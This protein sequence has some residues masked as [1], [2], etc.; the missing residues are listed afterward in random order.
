MDAAL[1]LVFMAILGVALLLYVILD[2]YD[3]GIGL[4]L[5]LATNTE[6]DTMIASIGPFWDANETWLVL[7]VGV[8]L[9]AFPVAYGLVLTALYVSVT[10]MLIGLILRG[11]AFDFRVKAAVKHK[12]MWNRA[13]AAGSLL[14]ATAQ[15]WMLGSYITGLV[16]SPVNT[17]FAALIALTLPSLYVVLGTGWLMMK[18][19]GPLFDKAVRWGL[20]A[21]P[22]M[23]IALLAVSVATPIVSEAIA[24]RWFT[25]PNFIG[26]APIPITTAIAFFSVLWV[27]K[28]FAAAQRGYEW[29]VFAGTVLTCV[30]AALGLAYSLY[31]YVVLGR[32]TVWEAAA[33]T[34]SLRFVLIGVSLAVP[35]IVGYTA[36]VYSV[37]RGK[38]SALTYGQETFDG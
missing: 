13:F 9:V 26:L 32:L 4:L 20:R 14:A 10:V 7:G 34:S 31:P 3:L 28:R 8:L 5:P 6:K 22:V 25:L 33:A 18:T 29:L 38:A 16:P 21:L 19:D 35:A 27:L 2:G 17:A 23:G 30:M 12:R 36:F 24:E 37:F 1:P 11:V 15:G